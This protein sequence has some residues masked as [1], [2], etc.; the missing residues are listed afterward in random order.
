M[1]RIPEEVA[2]QF[3]FAALEVRGSK[4]WIAGSPGT[5]VFHS[6]D[7][8]HR[9]FVASTGQSLPL[10]ALC[11][12]DDQK[13]WAVGQL[14]TILVTSDGGQTWKRQRAGGARAAVLGIF[15]EPAEIPLELFARLCGDEGYLG[16]VEALNRRDPEVP[17]RDEVGLVDRAHVA[18]AALG[19]A[20][21]HAAWQ[22]PLRQPGLHLPTE[23]VLEVWNE[24]HGGSAAG[25]WEAHVV[26]KSASGVPRSL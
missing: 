17:P 4:C 16:A 2:R 20:G 26:R 7:A 6:P 13:G 10:S 23:K 14:G 5:R 12:V 1:N 19:V 15:S 11:F 18:L 22:F 3:D 9:W 21:V 8:G 25:E 24:L